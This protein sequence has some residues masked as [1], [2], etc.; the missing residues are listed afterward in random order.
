MERKRA[1][2]VAEALPLDD[3]LARRGG[4]EGCGG[5]PPF[6]PALVA[7]HDALDLGLLEHDLRNE[8]RV[9]IPGPPPG[10]IAAALPVP[11]EERRLHAPDPTFARRRPRLSGPRT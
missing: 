9:G 11:G 1:P 2:V 6:E 8:D 10:K 3:H 5:R 7:R 4:C